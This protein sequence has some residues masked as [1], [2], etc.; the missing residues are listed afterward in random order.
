MAKEHFERH[1]QPWRADEAGM[2]R[3][4]AGKGKGLKE[5]AK[6]INSVRPW[7]DYGLGVAMGNIKMEKPADEEDGDLEDE[8]PQEPNP[9]AFQMG[10]VMPQFYQFLD[11]VSALKSM[12]SI[13]YEEEGLWVTH[14]ELHIEDLED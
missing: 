7:I 2:L 11:A 4:L 5:I 14:S 12:T 9:I 8:E 3:T 13:T 10:F 6:A 1:K